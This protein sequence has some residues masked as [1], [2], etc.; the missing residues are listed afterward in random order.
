MESSEHLKGFRLLRRKERVGV[1][2]AVC[3]DDR[4]FCSEMKGILEQYEE[5]KG[6]YI[7]IGLFS[8]GR[9]LC[10]SLKRGE[11]YDL[12]FLDILM[13]Q[14]NGVEAGKF[15]RN[16]MEDDDTKIVYV[17]SDEEHTVELFQNQPT[18]FL[19]KP[20]RIR[21]VFQTLDTIQRSGRKRQNQFFYK[22]GKLIHAIPYS[23]IIYYQSVGRKIQIHTPKE[24]YEYNGKLSQILGDGLPSDFICIH[25]SYIVNRNYIL[26]RMYNKVYLKEED[27]WLPVSQ[28]YRK[29]V[30]EYLKDFQRIMTERQMN[31]A[32]RI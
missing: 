32:N 28:I 15:I 24:I 25:K 27:T 18:D 20:V 5:S 19:K 22:Q 23:D 7:E 26:G 12:V 3:D 16:V 13:E 6:I 29:Q 10:K 17:S 9:E 1:R 21:R 4:R 8:D 11:R 31:F 30:R 14:V 2:I